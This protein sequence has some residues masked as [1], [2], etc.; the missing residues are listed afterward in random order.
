MKW[1]TTWLAEDATRTIYL[2]Q[3]LSIQEF[4]HEP[5]TKPFNTWNG[6][7]LVRLDNP[8]PGALA[9]L[10]QYLPVNFEDGAGYGFFATNHFL[11]ITSTLGDI[12]ALTHDGWPT[13]VQ[14][15]CAV[16]EQPQIATSKDQVASGA[17]LV[18]VATGEHHCVEDLPEGHRIS[19]LGPGGW[20]LSEPAAAEGD[21]G[22]REVWIG[23]P[24][25]QEWRRTGLAESP[26]FTDVHVVFSQ[27]EGD[28]LI[29][30]AYA[31]SDF[32]PEP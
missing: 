24:E 25:G 18:T 6:R 4:P 15:A 14:A 29:V 8:E 16:S 1:S 10:G 27:W 23:G 2:G 21:D 7:L 32:T 12:V 3:D 5:G 26:L 9:T 19:A 28:S 17:L 31:A 30:T 13:Q 22:S 11:H 20:L